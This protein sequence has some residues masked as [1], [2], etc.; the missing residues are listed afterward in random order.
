MNVRQKAFREAGLMLRGLALNFSE[1]P[2]GMDV[3]LVCA[4]AL[5]EY[6][7]QAL[8]FSETVTGSC[9]WLPAFILK[10]A[11]DYTSGMPRK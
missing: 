9:Q 7:E 2:N 4:E 11:I 8:T 1:L 3:C 10:P 5:E 6:A